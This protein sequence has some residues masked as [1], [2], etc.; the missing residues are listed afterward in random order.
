MK[1]WV[2]CQPQISSKEVYKHARQGHDM[3]MPQVDVQFVVVA[4]KAAHSRRQ[5]MIKRT[6][7]YGNK[8]F[9][10]SDAVSATTLLE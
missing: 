3:K 1:D 6:P 10:T 9:A 8:A 5:A 7:L 2:V 4:G